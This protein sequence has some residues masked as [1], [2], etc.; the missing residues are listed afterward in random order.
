MAAIKAVLN[1]AGQTGPPTKSTSG[2]VT[3][4]G[5]EACPQEGWATGKGE[6]SSN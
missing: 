6:P 3:S 2:A 5:L 1:Q 4:I